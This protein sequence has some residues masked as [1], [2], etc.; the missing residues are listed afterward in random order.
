MDASDGS[1]HPGDKIE[2]LVRDN[3]EVRVLVGALTKAARSRAFV[4]LWASPR[5]GT[6][7]RGN[8]YRD[9]MEQRFPR[10]VHRTPASGA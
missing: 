10:R 9:D 2:G 5:K 3:P 1:R 8:A 4:V 6:A 7:F